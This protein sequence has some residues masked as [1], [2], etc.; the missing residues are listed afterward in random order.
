MVTVRMIVLFISSILVPS[1]AQTWITWENNPP[2]SIPFEKSSDIIG[3]EYL[4]NSIY[5]YGGQSVAADTWYPTWS[6]N[7]N[8]YTPFTD[9]TI[10]L[11]NNKSITS[12]SGSGSNPS[13]NS[14]TGFVTVSG[15]NVSNLQL[16]S[17]GTFTAS[18][19]PYRGRYPCGSLIY[20]NTWFYGT[21]ML[22]NTDYCGGWCVQGPFVGFRWSTDWGQTWTEPRIKCNNAS[23]N[24][25]RETTENDK[26]IKFGAPHVVDFGQE[27]QYS[28]DKKLYIVGHGATRITANQSWMQGDQVYLARVIPIISSV[29]DSNEWEFYG[30]NNKWIKGNVTLAKPLFTWIN[31]TGVVTMTY[32]NVL[33]KYVMT[34]ST[35]DSGV[36]TQGAFDTYFLES[37]DIVGPWK[38]ITYM[39][40]F[41]PEA[42]FVNH[43]SKF[44]DTDIDTTSNTYTAYLSY[45]ANYA[46]NR[47]KQGNPIGSGYHWSL[48]HARFKLSAAFSKTIQSL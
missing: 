27:L 11:S 25:F 39:R 45:S 21:Y 23:D 43:P 32:F 18:T 8:L 48:L 22:N 34:V 35:P 6:S 10:I 13:Y 37:D 42:Y 9:G 1:I 7:G 15:N 5:N 16:I 20:N 33:K 40:E 28:G 31:R 36:G 29:N 46:L 4:N 41:G 3:W 17:G 38:Y 12:M 44:L 24:I 47:G 19:Y 30:G 26:K 14:T 2:S